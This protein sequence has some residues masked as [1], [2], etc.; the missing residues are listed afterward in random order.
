[1]GVAWLFAQEG[2]W[3]VRVHKELGALAAALGRADS[4]A[5]SLR[6]SSALPVGPRA[7]EQSELA[8]EIGFS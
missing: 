5:L 6:F 8:W 7:K 4:A 1:M 2:Y 3:R